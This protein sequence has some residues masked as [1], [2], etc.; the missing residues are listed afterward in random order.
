MMK[1]LLS[2]TAASAFSVTAISC[3]T[4]ESVVKNDDKVVKVQQLPKEH[5][6]NMWSSHAKSMQSKGKPAGN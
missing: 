3:S 5:Y 4:D 6:V 2:I 1:K